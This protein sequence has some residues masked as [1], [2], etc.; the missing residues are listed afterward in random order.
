MKIMCKYITI[1][2][3]SSM[4]LV[5]A[6]PPYDLWPLALTG[7]IPILI[8]MRQLPPI[9]AAGITGLTFFFAIFMCTS[10]WIPVL[11]RFAHL[12]FLT[13]FCIAVCICLYQSIAYGVWGY[14]CCFLK[15]RYQMHWMI[16]APLF[17][18]FA[19]T[20]LPFMFK[21]YL[22]ITVWRA[23]PL[24]Q[25][26]E[27]GGPPAVSGVIV[28][29]NLILL[30]TYLYFKGKP[31][32]VK[33]IKVG[34]ISLLVIMVFG[35]YRANH[36]GSA[37]DNQELTVGLIQPNFGIVTIQQ[38]NQNGSNYL[39]VL[40]KASQSLKNENVD[41]IVWP[42]SSWPYLFD[43]TLKKDYPDGHPWKLLH[44][45]NAR[46]F[47]GCLSHTFGTSFVLNSSVLISKNGDISGIADKNRLIPFAETIPFANTFQS[48]AKKWQNQIP[49]WPEIARGN[50]SKL[51]EDGPLKIAALICSEDLHMTDT[52]KIARQDSNLLI[53]VVNDAW[54]KD[55]AAAYQHLAL[56]S[57]RAIETRRY[58]VRGTNTGVSAIIDA[59][60]RVQVE[61]SL[62]NASDNKYHPADI[63]VGQVSLIQNIA[64]APY[65]ALFFPYVC[66]AV[67]IALIIP[68][69]D[70]Y[71]YHRSYALFKKINKF[72]RI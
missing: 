10:W 15:K 55:S 52:H 33:A 43:R 45:H 2:F 16:S 71:I 42:E 53:S 28:L 72:R 65:T 31:A 41:L 36:I 25:I 6:A 14:V 66:L 46:L 32:S 39:D 3:I 54:F 24:T 12:S 57:F 64:A 68:V 61:G 47:F 40:R 35:Y 63:Y 19:E 34:C 21:I 70:Q 27:I 56:A 1:S 8:C 62:I 17:I 4:M 49:E 38:R 22:S 26:A 23:W 29:I 50:T 20:L 30:E 37:I 58:L 13:S 60:G 18:V 9:Y 69:Q 48:I 11:N 51:L 59:L 5:L 7:L 67:M 44:N